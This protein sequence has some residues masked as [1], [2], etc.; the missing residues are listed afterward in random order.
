MA[1]PLPVPPVAMLPVNVLPSDS[2]RALA[3]D[4]A[5][6]L[7]GIGVEVG[8]CVDRER[9]VLGGEDRAAGLGVLPEKSVPEIVPLPDESMAPPKRLA[10]LSENVPPVIVKLPLLLTP[11]PLFDAELP[12]TS[13]P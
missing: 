12:V 5:A 6:F 7:G 8:A 9:A 4:R 11:P 10:V 2:Q 13:V 1:P 3:F